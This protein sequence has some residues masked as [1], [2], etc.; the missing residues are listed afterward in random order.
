M[1]ES[2]LII[3]VPCYNEQEMLDYTTDEL[4][5]VIDRL[6]Q[7]GKIGTGKILYVDD[8][9]KDA[10]WSIIERLTRRHEAVC[11]LKLAHNVGHQ[12]ALWAGLEWASLNGDVSISIDADLQDDTRAIDE[13]VDRYNQGTD[14]VYG[15]RK[16]RQTD[17]VFKRQTALMF[18]RLVRNLGEEIIY[19]HAD[20]RLMSRRALKALMT[21]PERNIFLRGMVPRIGL[22]TA[23]VY[24]D[25]KE[26]MAGESKY[27]FSKMFALA[28]DGITSFSVRPLQWIY[29][30]GFIMVFLAL[31]A[32]IYCLGVYQFSEVVWGWTSILIS[33]WFIGGATLVSIGIIGEYVGKIYREVKRRPR[34]FVEKIVDGEEEQQMG[35]DF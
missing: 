22:S 3:V 7:D 25:R 32:I 16:D 2:K 30:A 14:I 21:Y 23:C 5:K 20:F 29:I 9:S 15:V 6:Q 26:R 34:Y 35:R 11:G 4:L 19:N 12:N 18:Y 31:V 33:I 17:S 8:G 27:P 10:T 13:M 1:H 24:Y 28:M